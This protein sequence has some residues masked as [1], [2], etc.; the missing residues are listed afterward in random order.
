MPDTAHYP[1]EGSDRERCPWCG[2]AR[3]APGLAAFEC[4]VTSTTVKPSAMRPTATAPMIRVSDQ[5]PIC[6]TVV[7]LKDELE[8]ERGRAERAISF[9]KDAYDR[10][11][12]EAMGYAHALARGVDGLLAYNFHDVDGEMAARDEAEGALNAYRKANDVG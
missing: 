9:Q 8:R 2:S 3:K 10:G 1:I 4:G 7:A 6:R 12:A 5:T 11:Y